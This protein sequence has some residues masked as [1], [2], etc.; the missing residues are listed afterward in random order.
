VT[1]RLVLA[2]L[3][4]WVPLNAQQRVSPRNIYTRVLCIVPLV[5]S[6]TTDDPIR[7]AY[8]PLPSSSAP[9]TPP[10][11][12]TSTL[13][14]GIVAFSHQVSDDGKFALVEF[15]AYSRDAFKDLL[16]DKNPDIKVFFKG[17][18]KRASPIVRDPMK[19][20]LV[21]RHQDVRSAATAD[22]SPVMASRSPEQLRRSATIKSAST[23]VAKVRPP[24]SSSIFAS[25]A[26][27][28]QYIIG[29]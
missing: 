13:G 6:G 12:A 2:A 9:I 27:F 11:G 28:R 16:A 18:D 15:V 8:A 4:L 1:V 19:E 24:A 25:H 7:P 10:A 22:S 17:I 21:N 29:T 20:F 23:P 26:S 3:F 5:G 14:Q